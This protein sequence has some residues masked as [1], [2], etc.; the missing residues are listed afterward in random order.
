M[1]RSALSVTSALDGMCGQRTAPAALPQG[2]TRYSLH[3]MLGAANSRYGRMQK[4]SPQWD[5]IPGP[6]SP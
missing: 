2:K 4:I 3:R 1:Y 5:S 6:S